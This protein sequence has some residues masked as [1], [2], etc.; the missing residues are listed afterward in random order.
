L[1][2]LAALSP[3]QS[4][5]GGFYTAPANPVYNFGPES[6]WM[7]PAGMTG[8][9]TATISA[10]VG[11]FL[12]I[13]RFDASVAEAGGDDGKAETVPFAL[14]NPALARAE[15]DG[16]GAG[17]NDHGNGQGNGQGGGQRGRVVGAL[18]FRHRGSC[19][20]CRVFDRTR[21]RG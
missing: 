13:S 6:A 9:K 4:S 7:N 2:L 21:R 1:V 12:P 20:F 16:Q 10:S 19:P 8:I 14:E 15:R 18:R 11:G 17:G 5:A 3:A